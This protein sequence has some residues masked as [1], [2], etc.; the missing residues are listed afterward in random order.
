MRLQSRLSL[1]CIT[2]AAVMLLACGAA[3]DA[4][5]KDQ[6]S[7]ASQPSPAVPTSAPAAD[8][9]IE[10]KIILGTGHEACRQDQ[11]QGDADL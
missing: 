4:D 2:A 5:K 9:L 10:W 11:H 8:G 1:L 3:D 6:A 7:P